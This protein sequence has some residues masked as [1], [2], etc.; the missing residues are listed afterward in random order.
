MKEVLDG[1][2]LALLREHKGQPLLSSKSCDGTPMS[3]QHRRWVTLPS[4][5]V[6]RTSGSAAHE[7]LV[8]LQWVRALHSNN[9]H[10]TAV[11][12]QEA[13]PLHY[14]TAVPAGPTST[15]S[16]RLGPS[17]D[18]FHYPCACGVAAA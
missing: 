5:Q 9:D 12:L 11:L 1:K 6:V 3:T 4:G 17:R 16:L 10:D 8:K 13:M 18:T 14:G 7:F 2:Y 15:T